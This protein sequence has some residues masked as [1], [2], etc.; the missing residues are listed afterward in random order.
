M[1]KMIT[2][3]CLLLIL[4]G[5]A[6][7]KTESINVYGGDKLNLPAL[8]VIVERV[9]S[10][11]KLEY[12]LNKAGSVNNVGLNDSGYIDFLRVTEYGTGLIRG[13][14]INVQMSNGRV[15]EI[16]G[17]KFQRQQN[18]MVAV[19]F[20]GNPD[21][22]GEKQIFSGIWDGGSKPIFKYLFSAH[23]N[24]IS[25]SHNGSYPDYFQANRKLLSPAQ[26]SQ[27]VSAY[28]SLKTVERKESS[29]I[30]LVGSPYEGEQGVVFI[31]NTKT[32]KDRANKE[33]RKIIRR[34]RTQDGAKPSSSRL[35]S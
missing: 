19:E 7:S 3:S 20:I 16:A 1:R 8:A 14:S 17:V 6:C 12:E 35:D 27:L 5:S 26:Y 29:E 4:T 33:V 11:E 2:L 34:S 18:S 24:F 28:N 23:A 32:G 22:Y 13:L 30:I 21:V 9:E 25:R 15:V 10:A 31:D